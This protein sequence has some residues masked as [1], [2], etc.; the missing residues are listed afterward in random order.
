MEQLTKEH[1]LRFLAK[2]ACEGN[3]DQFIDHYFYRDF[4]LDLVKNIFY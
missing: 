4:S 3:N 2:A 1:G